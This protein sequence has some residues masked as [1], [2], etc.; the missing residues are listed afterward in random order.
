MPKQFQVFTHEFPIAASQTRSVVLRSNSTSMSVYKHKITGDDTKF[1][2]A[3]IKVEVRT[4][5]TYVAGTD[6]STWEVVQ[7]GSTSGLDARFV[8]GA[9]DGS[10]VI[11]VEYVNGAAR[12]GENIGVTLDTGAVVEYRFVAPAGLTGTTNIALVVSVER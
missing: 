4:G 5:G 12:G 7:G 11:D 6:L 2:D 9:G 8:S 10:N 3:K 1:D